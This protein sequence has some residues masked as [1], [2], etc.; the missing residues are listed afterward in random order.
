MHRAGVRGGDTVVVNG[1]GGIGTAAIQGARIAGAAVIVA[2]DPVAFKRDSTIRFGT[3]HAAATAKDA[4]PLVRDPTRGVMAHGVVLAPS[5]VGENDVS[6]AL[7]LTRKGGNCVV[8]GLAAPSTQSITPDVQGFTLMNT[9][10]RGTVFGSCNQNA[11]IAPLS[12]LYQAGRLRLDEMVHQALPT[13][14]R[15]PGL[16]RPTEQRI[17]RRGNRF[18]RE[19]A[20]PMRPVV[21]PQP[22]RRARVLEFGVGP[23]RHDA[24]GR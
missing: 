22:R 1:A 4:L 17:D 8:T 3:T 13:R 21:V 11:D 7:A 20:G 9:N 10:L 19:L 2:V 6:D 16:Y 14:R 18:R 24:P 5:L 15:E 23:L 12:R